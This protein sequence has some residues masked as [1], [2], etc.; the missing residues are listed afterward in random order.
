MRRYTNTL[1]HKT[2]NLGQFYTLLPVSRRTVVP[3]TTISNITANVKFNSAMLTRYI[4]SD[5]LL[6]VY[7]FYVPWRL[8]FDEFKEFLTGEG[9]TQLPTATQNFPVL[10]ERN[11]AQYMTLGRRAYKLIYNE[12]FGQET[13]S[14]YDDI[15]DDTVVG[16]QRTKIWDQANSQV[17]G[18]APF[19]STFVAP[20]ESEQVSINLTEFARSMRDARSKNRMSI[21]GDKY[22]DLMRAMGVDL[23]WRVQMA[24]EFLG[25]VSKKIA[26]F[27]LDS[28]EASALED[29][30]SRY[31]GTIDFS[32]R[33]RKSFAEY[34]TIW[35]LANCRPAFFSED[36]AVDT[37]FI[38][39]AD[40]F[41]GDNASVYE[42]GTY[43]NAR[44]M[45]LRNGRDMYGS[46]VGFNNLPWLTNSPPSRPDYPDPDQ[47]L[48]EGDLGGFQYSLLSDVSYKELTPV[49]PNRV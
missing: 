16:L 23:D 14:F 26:P 18:K 40:F 24:P 30:K 6:E 34:G 9:N 33:K 4:N 13:Q 12:F 1:K 2:G 25:K 43:N 10:F 28:S 21:T 48:T 46:E 29:R 22:V 35:L 17:T 27:T 3:G 36:A 11:Q 32:M 47:V 44:F 7:A 38:D 5:A 31:R 39:R 41:M 42:D 19:Q 8:V 49:P 15:T 20:V 37:A 45:Y